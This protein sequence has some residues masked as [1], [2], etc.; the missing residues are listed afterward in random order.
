[1]NADL[2]RICELVANGE[3]N[4]V[5]KL[6]LWR[7]KRAAILKRDNY[8][9]Q[10]CKRKAWRRKIVKATHVHHIKELKY[11]PELALDDDNLISLCFECHEEQHDRN[12]NNRKQP[13]FVNEE[14]W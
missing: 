10:H 9:C 14:R 11:Y 6:Q 3:E 8:E 12:E 13:K 1:M 2:S 4:K 5:Y 7:R